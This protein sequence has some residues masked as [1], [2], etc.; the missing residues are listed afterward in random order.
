MLAR[1]MAAVPAPWPG[2]GRACCSGCRRQGVRG[3]AGRQV[4]RNSATRTARTR[5]RRRVSSPGLPT[6]SPGAA[7]GAA[8]GTAGASGR[9]RRRR[10]TPSSAEFLRAE[11]RAAGAGEGRRRARALRPGVPRLPRRGRRSRGDLRLGLAGVPGHRGRTARG[12]GADRARRRPGRRRRP[13]W[14]P[15]P[16]YQLPG[17]GRAAGVDAGPVRPGDRRPRPAPTSTSPSRSGRWSA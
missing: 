2:T 17:H 9:G 11:L 10:R 3:P 13:R 6:V 8:R 7:A 4:R 1:R 14:T 16:R 5:A 12:G 15:T